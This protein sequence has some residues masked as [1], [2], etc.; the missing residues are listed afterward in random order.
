M[1]MRSVELF[2]D[3]VCPYAYLAFLEIGALE[4][5]TG[6]AVSLRPILLGGVFRAIGGPDDPNVAKGPAKARYGEID[7]QRMARDR[8]VTLRRPDEHPRRTVL[9][10]RAA[11]ASTDLASASRALFDA[12]WRDGKNLEDPVVVQAVLDAA[13]L[14]GAT[15]VR[16]A[17]DDAIKDELRARTDEAVKKGVFG[18]PTFVVPRRD[19]SEELFWGVD[20]RPHVAAALQQPI[21]VPFYFDYSSPFAYLA[22]TQ[23][24][25]LA[26]RTNATLDY[27]PILLGGLFKALGTPNVPLFE[28]PEPKR[29]Y[30]GKD[31]HRWAERWGVPFRFTSRFP[32]STVKA[33]RLTLAADEGVRPALVDALFRA[34]WVEDRDIADSSE[35]QRIA[36]AVG[37]G[38]AMPRVES[39]PIKQG[40]FDATDEARAR[41]VFGVPTF[42]LGDDPYWGQDRLEDLERALLARSRSTKRE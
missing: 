34:L 11:I 29:V 4:R 19:G 9:A 26:A 20:R 15:A 5:E 1:K 16:R 32:M 2:Y 3:F 18:V 17:S 37:A 27:K 40:L 41:G 10:L 13:G 42:F 39:A 33:L 23:V 25:G 35:L 8:G 21:T 38:E 14:D 6:A 22:A 31:L 36:E 28:M 7:L 12:Y 24:R 30:V